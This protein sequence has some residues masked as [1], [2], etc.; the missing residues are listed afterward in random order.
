M[1]EI[2]S[3][4]LKKNHRG[5]GCLNLTDHKRNDTVQTSLDLKTYHSH[6]EACIYHVCQDWGSSNGDLI[7]SDKLKSSCDRPGANYLGTF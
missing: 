2:N 3:T 6:A 1:R 4:K 7:F 5:R